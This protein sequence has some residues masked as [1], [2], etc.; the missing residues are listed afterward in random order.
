MSAN[1]LAKLV[2]QYVIRNYARE[3]A[4]LYPEHLRGEVMHNP[5]GLL[6]LICDSLKVSPET[7]DAWVVEAQEE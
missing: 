1:Q 7:I 4:L 2:V 6:D 3:S 5:K